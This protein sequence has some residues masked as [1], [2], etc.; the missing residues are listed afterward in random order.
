MF[1][2]TGDYPVVLTVTD[3]S[4]NEAMVTV[5]VEVIDST[6]T[7]E[8]FEELDEQIT[9]YPVPTEA[10]LNIAT[11]LIIDS[12]EMYDLL[13]KQIMHIKNPSN[14]ID[15]SNVSQGMYLLK[16]QTENKTL[17]KRFIKN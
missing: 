1:T 2:A 3:G 17:I 13:G 15:V 10:T 9:I 6:L 5:N 4:G 16:F 11:D 8:N 12:I 7:I 14:K